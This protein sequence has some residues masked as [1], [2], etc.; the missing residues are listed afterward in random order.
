[1]LLVGVFTSFYTKHDFEK[2]RGINSYKAAT[3]DGVSGFLMIGFRIFFPNYYQSGGMSGG[4]LPNISALRPSNE[5]HLIVEFVPYD[6]NPV[7]L[8]A[9]TGIVYTGESWQDGRYLTNAEV[10]N[11]PFF[12]VESMEEEAKQLAGL[13][14]KQP[15]KYGKGTRKITTGRRVPTMSTTLILRNLMITVNIQTTMIHHISRPTTIRQKN[16]PIIPIS[17]MRRKY[18]K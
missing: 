6:T 2:S 15:K 18:G 11:Y 12:R 8:K 16:L 1:M 7:Y 17:I 4:N 5:T 3:E 13:Y 9:Y 14:K 10:G